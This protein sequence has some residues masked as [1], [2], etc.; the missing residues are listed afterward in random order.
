M[1]KLCD[2]IIWLDEWEKS[3]REDE[4]APASNE[5]IAFMLYAASVYCKTG[6]K[7]NFAEVFNRPDL[8]RAMAPYYL[9]IDKIIH[10]RANNGK[11]NKKEGNQSYDAEKI[12]VLAMKGYTQK[13][14]CRVLG[15][16]ESKSRSLSTN[17]GYRTGK[18]EFDKLSKEQ[19]DILKSQKKLEIE[20]LTKSDSEM[21]LEKSD[22]FESENV[23]NESEKSE[24]IDSYIRDESGKIVG[25][26]W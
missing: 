10:F 5:D 6:N 3:L 17:T 7:T 8:N 15:Y 9:Q 20:N 12:K 11:N 23:R 1:A 4:F 14:I 25:F 22:N 26:N 19:K 16:D 18:D 2:D 24:L 21:M 13:E